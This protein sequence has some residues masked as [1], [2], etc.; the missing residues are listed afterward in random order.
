M[1]DVSAFEAT[2]NSNKTKAYQIGLNLAIL[3]WSRGVNGG[4]RAG[5][6]APTR[7]STGRNDQLRMGS[8]SSMPNSISCYMHIADPT[9]ALKH[10][11]CNKENTP[12]KKGSSFA[13]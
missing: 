1:K 12:A 3:K 7:R 13:L 4:V 2:N 5:P 9:E 11:Y 6:S 8:H 10:N